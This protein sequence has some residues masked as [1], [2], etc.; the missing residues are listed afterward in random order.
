[1][2]IDWLDFVRWPWEVLSLLICLFVLYRVFT[3]LLPAADEQ[4]DRALGLVLGAGATAYI[5][6]Q[7]RDLG[8]IGIVIACL[9]GVLIVLL[10][11][12]IAEEETDEI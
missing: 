4:Q 11:E 7:V 2:N 3:D 12:V 6:R 10:S 9:A 1:M 5:Y 8:L